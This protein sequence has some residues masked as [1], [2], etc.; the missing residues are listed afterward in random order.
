[1]MDTKYDHSPEL[2]APS[3]APEVYLPV[4][5]PSIH[6][7]Q[8]P[9]KTEDYASP[10]SNYASVAAGS[11]YSTLQYVPP[12]QSTRGEAQKRLQCGCSLVVLILSIIIAALSVAVIGLAAGT[13]I[14]TN[15]YNEA[16]QKL[17]ALSSE[18]ASQ[19][20]A[21]L[22]V[23]DTI[24]NSATGT[25]TSSS[26]SATS[27][28]YSD[29]TNGCSDSDETTTG[30]TYKSKFYDGSSYT[31][32]CN[33]DAPNGGLFSL[34]TGNFDGCMEACTAWNSFN[35][36]NTTACAA[37]SFIPLWADIT[38]AKEGDAPG[39]CYLKPGPQD[40]DNL[41]TPNIGTE[42]HAAIQDS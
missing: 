30:E 14:A 37:V 42:C 15:N 1:M 35:A 2:A 25:A 40:E 10:T 29:I 39:D 33:R 20:T 13:G 21:T 32:Y 7:S 23:T 16:N 3:D 34:F 5:V 27:T 36:T 26:E 18:Y 38:V 17:E 22:T 24:T 41:T 19:K 6:G 31:M 9:L 28:S 11:A 12:A 8:V 4:R